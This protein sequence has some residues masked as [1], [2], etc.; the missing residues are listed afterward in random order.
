MAPQN[1]SVATQALKAITTRLA[2]TPTEKLPR[3]IPH[4]ANTVVDIRELLSAPASQIQADDLVLVH[5]FKSQ[6]TSLVQDK[7]LEARWS[8]I[9]LIKAA[10]EV[11]GWEVLQCSGV[12]I[13]AL[14]SILGVGHIQIS[15][16]D[17]ARVACAH[18]L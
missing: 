16:H 2:N 13:R 8:A 6:L 9:V 4:L 12:W 14:L 1:R 3:V 15:S 17:V 10:V 18:G 7:S 11:G 5:K